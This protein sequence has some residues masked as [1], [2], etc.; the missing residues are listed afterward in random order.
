MMSKK[1]R[2]SETQNKWKNEIPRRV[3]FKGP[4]ATPTLHTAEALF[5]ISDP[6]RVIFL[7]LFDREGMDRIESMR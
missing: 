6:I 1:I 5:I 4:F 7:R 3:I 2:D